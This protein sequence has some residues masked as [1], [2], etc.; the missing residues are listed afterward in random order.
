MQILIA[1]GGIAGAVCAIAL[2]QAGFA[3]DIHEAFERDADGVGAFLTLGVNGLDALRVVG[4]DVTRLGGFDTPS[5][6]LS[7]GNGQQLAE[8]NNG[9]RRADGL[10]ARTI[11][12]SDLYSA[13]RGEAM[14]RGARVHYG[15]RLAGVHTSASGGVVARFADGSQAVGDVLVGADGLHSQVRRIIDPQAPRARYVGLLNTGGYA[16]GMKVPGAIGAMHMFFGKRCFFAYI[17]HPNGQVLWFANPARAKEPTREELAAITPEQWRARLH[18]LF[19]DDRTPACGII[20]ATRDILPAWCT[21]DFP[22]VPTWFRERMIIIGDAAHAASPSS[23]QGAS[24][25][26]EDAVVLARCLRDGSSVEASFVRYESL[27]R[28][29]VEKVVAQGKKNGTGKTPGPLGR[30][31][32]DLALRVIFSRQRGRDYDPMAWIF[33][34]H[35]VWNHRPS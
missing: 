19:A 10:V 1:G 25:A 27:R 29:R 2:R 9:P 18:E 22:H 6:T 14:Q 3:A 30:W 32:R 21:Y 20:R 15:K 28:E 26:I 7:L 16:D 12:R 35:I 5:M 33:N 24:M 23:G 13:L 17:P 34:H 31:A 4:V 11:R 8:F